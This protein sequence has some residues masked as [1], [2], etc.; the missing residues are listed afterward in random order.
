[1][2]LIGP[3][4]YGMQALRAALIAIPLLVVAAT[5]GAFLIFGLSSN[6]DG[7]SP[8]IATETTV[9]RDV[10]GNR[11]IL[12]LDDAQV[13]DF[14]ITL[15]FESDDGSYHATLVQPSASMT[16]MGHNMGATLVPMFRRSDGTW[17][18][19]G[20]FP[21]RGRWRFQIV[22]D[23]EAVELEHTAR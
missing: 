8:R 14:E 7:V 22:F 2:P 15:M 20:S 19:T 21:M 6:R 1:M 4:R 17:S 9:V 11:L 16:M 23:G 12:T 18:G 3:E 10:D 13:G 5:V